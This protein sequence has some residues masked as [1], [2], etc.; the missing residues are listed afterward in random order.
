MAVSRQAERLVAAERG[1]FAQIWDNMMDV[2][3]GIGVENL[4]WNIRYIRVKADRAF[5]EGRF[6]DANHYE[7]VLAD[8]DPV[9]PRL[10]GGGQSFTNVAALLRGISLRDGERR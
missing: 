7:D 6:A 2:R 10:M 1:L 5:A 3:R 9:R 4:H 8:I